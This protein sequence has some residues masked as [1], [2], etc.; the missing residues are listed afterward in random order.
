MPV[1]YTVVINIPEVHDFKRFEDALE[2]VKEYM[3]IH[4][5]RRMHV[6]KVVATVDAAADHTVKLHEQ[7]LMTRLKRGT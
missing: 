1:R 6:V 7:G 5:E 3:V 4:R 2:Y